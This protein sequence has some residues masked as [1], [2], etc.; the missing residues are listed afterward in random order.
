MINVELKNNTLIDAIKMADGEIKPLKKVHENYNATV[1]AFKIIIDWEEDRKNG[2]ILEFNSD[3][4][5]I[6]KRIVND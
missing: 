2:F 5:K 6:R 1:E 4:S 3:Y